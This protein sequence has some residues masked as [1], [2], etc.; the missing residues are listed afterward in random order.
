MQVSQMTKNLSEV[1]YLG[2]VNTLVPD[3]RGGRHNLIN[4]C[5]FGPCPHL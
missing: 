4:D 2:L 1:V 5:E 3:S